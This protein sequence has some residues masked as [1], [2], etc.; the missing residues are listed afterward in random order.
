MARILGAS[1]T[2]LL[3]QTSVFIVSL[4][5]E[6]RVCSDLQVRILGGTG[7]WSLSPS[8]LCTDLG[9]GAVVNACMLLQ[10]LCL[11][12]HDL[13]LCSPQAQMQTLGFIS[14]QG[15]VS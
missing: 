3:I 15:Q 11:L 12:H 1:L 13:V 6:S 5:Q 8:S 14:S 10:T 2:S 7:N 4:L 9:K